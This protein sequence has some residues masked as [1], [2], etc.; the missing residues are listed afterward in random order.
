MV[1][2]TAP[3]ID[4][5]VQAVALFTAAEVYN[6]DP[7]RPDLETPT[8]AE[9][10]AALSPDERRERVHYL[11]DQAHDIVDQALASHLDGRKVVAVCVLYSG[12]NDSTTLAHLFHH[13]A[14]HAIHANTTIGIESTREFVRETCKAWGLPLIEKVAPESYRDLVLGND[15]RG[16]PRGFPGPAMHFFYYTRLKERCLDAARRDLITN[17]RTE[18]VLFL[19]GRRRAESAR[20]SKIPLY[21]AQGSVI[22]IS[23]LAMWTKLD[24]NTYRDIYTDVPRNPASD[25]IHMSG[26]CLCGAFAH[27]GE[28][29]EVGEWFPEVVA[30]IRALEAEVEA[31]GVPEPY[32]RWGHGEGKP[33]EVGR[34][35]G[36]CIS[37]G[38]LSFDNLEPHA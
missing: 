23:P 29:D 12:G 9:I 35:C 32:C 7:L 8:P 21:E 5:L 36:N 17:G 11:I 38:Q 1:D 37:R 28:L 4:P 24:L 19:G 22:W 34:A 18:R 13:E 33:S 25:L 3:T 31:A 30:E 26:E 16:I 15:A 20:R 10:V 27:P 14:T 6:G 2:D